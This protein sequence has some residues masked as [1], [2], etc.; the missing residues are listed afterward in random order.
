MS[1]IIDKR[2]RAHLF[3][4][5]MRAA[6]EGRGISRAGLARAV[7]IDRSTVTQMLSDT[8]VRMP[9]GHVVASLATVLGVSADWLLGLSDRPEQV[10]EM[11]AT[12]LS[13][14]ETRRATGADDQIF[15]WHE[16]A[17]GYKIRHVPATLPDVL[18]TDALMRWEYAPE[19]VKTPG[20]AIAAAHAR[21][22]WLRGTTSDYEIAFPLHE[23]ESFV[24]GTGYYEGLDPG[25]RRE[26]VDWFSSVCDELFPGLRLFLFDARQVY[27]APLTV[28]GPRLAVIY[29]GH[30]YVAFR[31]RE[32]V[33][34][35]SRH[36]DGLVREAA[37]SDREFGLHLATLREAL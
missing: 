8:D 13:I 25:I 11:L 17:A 6:M 31:D 9:G 30:H 35:M 12:S 16:E 4:D 5:R 10:D 18:K 1:G 21:L 14:S 15:A 29:I 37:V 36:F 34:A 22:D 33:Q 7:G 2:A 19:T 23:L 32:R 24:F 27:S 3:R 26:Q 20:Q 28:F